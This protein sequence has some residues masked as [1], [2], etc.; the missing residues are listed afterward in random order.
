M[1]EPESGPITFFTEDHRRC[2]STWGE[3]EEHVA[4]GDDAAA[5][6]SWKAF[7]DQ[8]L[9]HLQMEEEVLFPAFEAATGM[10]GG[11]TAVMRH[12]HGQMR[13][14]VEQMAGAANG[15]DLQRVLD[16]G[17][18]LLMLIQQHNAKEEAMLYPMTER[19]LAGRWS[20]IA[21]KLRGYL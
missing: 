18:T 6:G 14:L 13:G 16:Q 9:L 10:T 5:Q 12:E 1:A 8:L 15:G 3:F 21:Q 11:P 19:A 2:D 20:E 4:S 7:H 17:D